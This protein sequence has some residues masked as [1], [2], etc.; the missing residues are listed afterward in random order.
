[1]V[2]GARSWY[3]LIP[4]IPLRFQPSEMAKMVLVVVLARYFAKFPTGIAEWQRICRRSRS[5]GS[6]CVAIEPDMGTVAVIGM[7]MLI[8]FHL[9]GAKFRYL[10]LGCG[11][12]GG[13]GCIMTCGA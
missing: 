13:R 4:G 3:S 12:V 8:Y 6:R 9:A 5:G 7:A 2:N 10:L 1:M 11:G